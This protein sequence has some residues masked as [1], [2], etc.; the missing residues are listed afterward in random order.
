MEA[1]YLRHRA[2]KTARKSRQFNLT[3]GEEGQSDS[4]FLTSFVRG[5]VVLGPLFE[6]HIL[7]FAGFEDFAAFL[8]LD[9]FRLFVAAYDLH[10]GMLAGLALHYVLRRSG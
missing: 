4:P 8:A 3:T 1:D 10:A 2:T 6:V 5:S 7:E 9:E